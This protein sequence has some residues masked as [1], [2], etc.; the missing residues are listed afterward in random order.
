MSTTTPEQPKGNFVA[1]ENPRKGDGLPA[2]VGGRISIPGEAEEF[3]FSLWAH[4]YEKTDK[5]TGEVQTLVSFGGEVGELPR[6]SSAQDRIRAMGEPVKDNAADVVDLGNGIKLRARQIAMFP[7]GFKDE[8]PEKDR[9]D[10][11]GAF[12]PG[13]GKPVVRIGTWAR[14]KGD[15]AYFTGRTSYPIPGKTEAEMQDMEQAPEH[16][17]DELLDQG[18]VAKGEDGIRKGRGKKSDASL[19]R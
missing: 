9:P 13:D 18:V 7:N 6:G 5:T 14:T 19:S 10:Y 3:P 11:W 16:T 8:A 2:F 1:F 4:K 17:L 15:R 12:Y